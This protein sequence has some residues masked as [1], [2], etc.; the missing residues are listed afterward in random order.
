MVFPNKLCKGEKQG[1]IVIQH[2]FL[3]R[4]KERNILW[5]RILEFTVASLKKRFDN[6]LNV[7]DVLRLICHREKH[8]CVDQVLKSNVI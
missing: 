2:M 3:L 7:T 8:Y 6:L 5:N 4:V 1:F